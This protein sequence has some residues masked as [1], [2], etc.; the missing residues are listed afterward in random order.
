MA[1]IIRLNIYLSFDFFKY[2]PLKLDPTVRKQGLASSS[3]THS[4]PLRVSL[5]LRSDFSG[6]K[7]RRAKQPYCF[8]LKKKKEGRRRRRN[9]GFQLSPLIQ[10]QT[11]FSFLLSIPDHLP[12]FQSSIIFLT[13]DSDSS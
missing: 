13:L 6:H 8:D 9:H 12:P 4:P 7:K 5:P 10:I 2:N 11:G 1:G 3:K